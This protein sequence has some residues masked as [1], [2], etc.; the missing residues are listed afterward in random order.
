VCV[1]IVPTTEMVEAAYW[2]A[3]AEDAA[4]VWN[5]MISEI[6]GGRSAG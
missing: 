1:P 6:Q 2:A 3:H 5:E 4:R